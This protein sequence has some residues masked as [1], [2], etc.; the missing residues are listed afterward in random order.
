MHHRSN[1]RPRRAD[2]LPDAAVSL[3]APE[4][5]AFA[6]QGLITGIYAELPSGKEATVTCCRAHPS[7]KRRFLAAKLYRE[8]TADA[9]RRRPIYFEGRDRAAD[10][11][12]ARAVARGTRFGHAAA[13]QLWIDA[14]VNALERAAAAGVRVPEP[15]ARSGSAVLMAFLG[16]GAGP[17]PQ[18]H[19]VE[20][21]RAGAEA[22][23]EALLADVARLLR[24][25]LVHGDLSP[26]NVLVW[27]G[28]P[29]IIDL[30]Q[31]VD[32]RFNRSAFALLRRDVETICRFFARRGVPRDP[33]AVALDL[34]D[35]YRRAEL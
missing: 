34:W 27:D 15:I 18:L 4:L 11:R 2:L 33:F 32:A 13:A 7:T 22:L 1:V 5:D 9:Y 23:F 19:G 16:N 8:H 25:H 28:A 17:A 24:E 35:R 31:A 20:T 21:D 14:E 3:G 6:H 12:V 30:P 10:P 26:Y 29:W